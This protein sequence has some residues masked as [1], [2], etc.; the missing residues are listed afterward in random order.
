MFVELVAAD[1][2]ALEDAVG[3]TSSLEGMPRPV[4]ATKEELGAVV[5]DSVEVLDSLVE[6]TSPAK[7]GE[8]SSVGIPPPVEATNCELVVIV[9][10]SVE[11]LELVELET[12]VPLRE[13]KFDGCLKPSPSGRVLRVEV[14]V[15]GVDDGILEGA[16]GLTDS[17]PNGIPD[18]GCCE[19]CWTELA[20]ASGEVETTLELVVVVGA[21]YVL[22][23]DVGTE[24]G[25][26]GC[27][28]FSGMPPVEGALKM[29]NCSVW[30]S[31]S[32]LLDVVEVVAGEEL[33]KVGCTVVS[34]KP[35][36]GS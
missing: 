32:S 28:G 35:R 30:V 15:E 22:D 6:L 18:E 34:G 9:A 17:P 25:P 33:E 4:E 14:V 16:V 31:S 26:V 13:V 3:C 19:D 12:P 27:T 24:L 7:V 5:A 10:E 21:E 1:E 29:P 36:D 2:A 23:D 8:A 11:L 20:S